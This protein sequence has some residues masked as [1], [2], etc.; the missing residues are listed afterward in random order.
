MWVPTRGFRCWHPGRWLRCTPTQALWACAPQQPGTNLGV[1]RYPGFGLCTWAA[2]PVI[3][4]CA[5]PGFQ[6]WLPRPLTEVH[7]HLGFQVWVRSPLIWVRANRA[8]A[9]CCGC[10]SRVYSPGAEGGGAPEARAAAESSLTSPWVPLFSL[11][12]FKK[13]LLF[14]PSWSKQAPGL[15]HSPAWLSPKN[16]AA[17]PAPGPGL[18]QPWSP[19][20]SQGPY[21]P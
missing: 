11:F 20:W 5:H 6:F 17:D 9:V 21:C 16:P 18:Q 2:K 7:A 3:S 8:S 1:H 4:V 12:L 10:L 15:S 14:K 19:H 13:F